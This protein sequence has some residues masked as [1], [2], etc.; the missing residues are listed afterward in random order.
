ML[1]VPTH[2]L[3]RVRQL[4]ARFLR[5]GVNGNCRWISGVLSASCFCSEATIS[6]HYAAARKYRDNNN[7]KW[8][9]FIS[10]MENKSI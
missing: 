4:G 3:E 8:I 10:G 9:N 6:P 5:D 2:L 1:S 7:D